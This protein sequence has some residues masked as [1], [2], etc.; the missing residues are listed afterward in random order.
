MRYPARGIGV[1]WGADPESAP[2]ALARLL[3]DR[4]AQLLL[5]LRARQTTAELA[6]RLDVTPSA[7]SQHLAPLRGAGL[8]TSEHL[9]RHRV[10]MI[11]PLGAQLVR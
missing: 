9:G 11:S 2:D 10:H 4:R 6:R 7:I 3:G 8:I 5:L 1:L